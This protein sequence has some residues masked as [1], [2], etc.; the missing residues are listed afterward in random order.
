[1]DGVEVFVDS[2]SQGMVNKSTPLRL[3]GIA[4]GQHTIQGVHLGYEP[5][6]PR[7][8]NVYPGQETTVSLKIA[9]IRRKNR[10]ATDKVDK[11]L[12]LY[13]KGSKENYKKAAEQFQQA[14][15][16]DPNYS[17]AAL[18]LART[19]DALFDLDNADKYYRRAIEID[20]DYTEA[21]ASY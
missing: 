5:D 14:L 10:A 2:I 12:A 9:I 3:P 13:G 11:G 16:L 1:M 8:E 7:Q 18:A 17:Q 21:H 6:G 4:P 15:S 20:P 19:Y